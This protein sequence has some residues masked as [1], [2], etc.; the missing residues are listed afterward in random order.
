MS[1]RERLI[2]VILHV[3]DL[4]ASL[5]FYRDLVGVPLERGLN[6]PEDDPWYGGHHVELSWRD[7][8][9]LHFALFPAR[10]VDRVTSG[11]E[12]GFLADD[13]RA[14]HERM[15]A[16]GATVLHEPRPEPWGLTARYRDPDGNV[17]GITS[18]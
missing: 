16:G 15:R 2:V 7:G 12:L 11:V 17:V 3:A 10:S 9:Y 1:D 18:R 5:L 6:L 14:T 4:E 13:V 8:A